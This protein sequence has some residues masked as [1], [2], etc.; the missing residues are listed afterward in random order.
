MGSTISNDSQKKRELRKTKNA[1]RK[2]LDDY[3]TKVAKM[4]YTLQVY[5]AYI[6][7]KK[8]AAKQAEESKEE[9]DTEA[10]MQSKTTVN[11]TPCTANA[12]RDTDEN[13]DDEDD[14][15]DD[16]EEVS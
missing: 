6:A 3:H 7:E 12:I 8:E 5:H 16:D 13:E 14:D 11:Q 1:L 4:I 10:P 2:R 9:D 15:E